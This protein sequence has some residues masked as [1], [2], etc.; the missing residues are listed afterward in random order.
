MT[1]QEKV[2]LVQNKIKDTSADFYVVTAL[3][4]VAWLFNLRASDI[5]NNPMFFAY[6]MVSVNDNQH[7]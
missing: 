3:D 4:E 5:P 6:A 2:K 7:R 1:W